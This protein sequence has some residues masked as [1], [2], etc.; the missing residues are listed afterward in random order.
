MGYGYYILDDGREAG[1]NVEATCDATGCEETIDR[2][3]GYLCGMNPCGHKE[4]QE[5]GCA[6]YYCTQ[7]LESEKHD[8]TRP[9]CGKYSVDELAV[10]ELVAGHQGAHYSFSEE[11][12]FIEV[13]DY[14]AFENGCDQKTK[15]R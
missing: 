5:Y 2:G 14:E 11:E 15:K 3:L 12:E 10:C 8:C 9:Q 6:N 4:P 7:H 1:Y 13:F